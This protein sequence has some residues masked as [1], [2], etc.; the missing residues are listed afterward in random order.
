MATASI[1][2]DAKIDILAGTVAGV[3][4]VGIGHPL[5]TLKVRL[6]TTGATLR[7]D[8]SP[9]PAA[10]ASASSAA[11][12]RLGSI[13]DAWRQTLRREGIKG[14]Y[15]GAASPLAG[16]MVQ[17]AAGFLCWG[18]SKKLVTSAHLPAFSDPSTGA[19]TL[20]GLFAAGLL[21]GSACLFVETPIDLLKTQ[22]QVQLGRGGR[23]SGVRDV[24]GSIYRRRGV[25]GL[26]QGLWSNALRFVPGRA[27]YMSSFEY[28]RNTLQA[29]GDEGN[30]VR[31]KL[32]LAG[33]F[34][35]AAAWT[36]TYPF[37]VVRNE[38]VVVCD[39]RCGALCC[40]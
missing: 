11:H 2:R 13:V 12:P 28:S 16:G 34:A 35:G 7:V 20:G 36:S 25:Q 27:V 6:Q 5:D 38:R 37:D 18:V 19:L 23:Y 15:K 29:R 24:A 40:T 8:P 26:F 31:V 1:W 21:T 30:V 3:A 10:S 22:M 33:A 39:V 9:V 32:F 17:N 4:Q 14:L